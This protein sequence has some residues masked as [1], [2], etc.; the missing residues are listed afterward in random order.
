M[1]WTPTSIDGATWA[2]DIEYNNDITVGSVVYSP[3]GFVLAGTATS[4]KVLNSGTPTNKQPLSFPSSNHPGG[5]VA[6]FCDGHVRY[7]N[8]NIPASVYSQ[9]MTSKSTASSTAPINYS[10]LPLFDEG[11]LN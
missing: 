3:L 6:A 7:L 2:S 4:G 10:T 5:V 1:T 8:D 9:L 11:S